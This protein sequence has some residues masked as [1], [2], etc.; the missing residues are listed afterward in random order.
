VQSL[1][2]DACMSIKYE[3]PAEISDHAVESGA[4]ISDHVR[5]GNDTFSVELVVSN[6]PTGDV[7]FGTDGA[8]FSPQ[9][10]SLGGSNATTWQASS[11]FDRVARADE[12]FMSFRDNATLLTV[13]TS[14][15]TAENVVVQN[16]TVTRDVETGNILMASVDF[17]K[18]RI[19]STQRTTLPATRPVQRRGQQN[20]N[21]GNQ[22]AQQ[23]PSS[24]LSRLGAGDAAAQALG[25]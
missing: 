20:Q 14:L 2:I 18:L 23:A 13:Q 8:T 3:S 16:Y 1:D 10:V 7:S 21:R 24:L 15:R 6:T 25:H 11:R 19:V 22:P 9:S 12:Q 17:R 5:P 4:A